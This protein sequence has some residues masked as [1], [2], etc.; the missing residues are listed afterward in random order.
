VLVAVTVSFT[1]AVT[2][3]LRIEQL[4]KFYWTVVTG[5]AAISVV[6]AWYGL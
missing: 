2:A 6:L 4:F 1:H 3:R 5:L